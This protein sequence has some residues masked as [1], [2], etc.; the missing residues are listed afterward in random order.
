MM[1]R[2]R[3]TA[4]KYRLRWLQGSRQLELAAHRQEVAVVAIEAVVETEV[5]VAA[6][7]EA[8]ETEV[9]VAVVLA[10]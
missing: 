7:E 8:V 9:V 1:M 3:S 5:A 6:V 10:A 4:V 2:W